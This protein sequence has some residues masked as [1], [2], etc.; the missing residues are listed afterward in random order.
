M[1]ITAARLLSGDDTVR[2]YSLF[3]LHQA[4]EKAL[5]AW[6]LAADGYAPDGH[7]IVYLCKRAGDSL[8][9]LR[10]YI[11]LCADLNAYYISAR[12]PADVMD[13]PQ[14]DELFEDIRQTGALREAVI[15]HA[16]HRKKL[17]PGSSMQAVRVA[18]AAQTAKTAKTAKTAVSADNNT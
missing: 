11:D 10:K 12:Y 16:L 1:D 3:H 14:W 4:I 15:A 17:I 8:P 6:F 7:N 2:L 5:K 18:Q 9:E 13:M